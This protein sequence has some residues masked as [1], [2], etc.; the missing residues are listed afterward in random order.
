VPHKTAAL[1]WVGAGADHLATSIGALNTIVI[2]VGRACGHNTDCH[3]AIDS[4]VAALGC[5]R[6]DLA[7]LS[8]DVLGSGGAARAVL[9]GLSD[10]GCRVTVYGRSVENTHRLAERFNA[11]PASWAE[12]VNR[13][14]ALLINCTRVGMWPAV[15]ESPMPAESLGGC[16]L[17]F[18]LIY[19]PLETALLRDTRSIGSTAL[20][21]LDMFIRQAA[22]QYELWTAQSPDTELARE[23]IADE[24][25]SVARQPP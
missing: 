21:G 1:E 9:A 22:M 6:G 10:Y 8:V 13:E 12:R 4:A 17:V 3:A 25:R 18:D 16:R 7:E 15:D 14:G 5:E 19:N 23:L 20:N 2:R 11:Q 24:L